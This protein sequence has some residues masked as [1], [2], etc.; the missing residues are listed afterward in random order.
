MLNNDFQLINF[1]L[2]NNKD[3]DSLPFIYCEV[4]FVICYIIYLYSK[5]YAF[6]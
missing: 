5:I 2:Y 6:L 4:N 3:M 1:I